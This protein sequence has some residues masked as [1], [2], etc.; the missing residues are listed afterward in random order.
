MARRNIISNDLSTISP[1]TC[2]GC[3]YDKVRRHQSRYKGI[4]NKKD[5]RH[6]LTP[7]AVVSIDQLI[8]PTPGFVPIHR[9]LPTTKRYVGATIFVDHYSDFTYVH[10]MIETTA[11]TTVAAKEAFERLSAS[12]NVHIC[13]YHYANGLFDTSAFKTS[14]A[15]AYQTISF[16]GVNTHH[17]N[18]KDKRHIGDITQGTQR[19]LLYA[20]YRPYMFLYGHMPCKIIQTYVTVFLPHSSKEQRLVANV[21]VTIISTLPSIW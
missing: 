17:H 3:A 5:I 13:H 18:G 19:F 4:Q 9:D 10:L 8:S 1:P 6:G 12:H 15:A 16:Y 7:D 2:L 20:S 11:V 14:I 21:S